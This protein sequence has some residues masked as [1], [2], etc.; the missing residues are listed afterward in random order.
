MESI[1]NQNKQ[2]LVDLTMNGI[3]L[4]IQNA[5]VL[6]L[7]VHFRTIKIKMNFFYFD[8][9]DIEYNLIGNGFIDHIQ[10]LSPHNYFTLKEQPEIKHC[11][12]FEPNL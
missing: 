12:L 5:I 7:D 6:I 1:C 10:S 2:C 3:E 4:G 9:L 11:I 8:E